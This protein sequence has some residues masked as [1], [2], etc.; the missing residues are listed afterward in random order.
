RFSNRAADGSRARVRRRASGD[1][2]VI[3][4]MEQTHAAAGL[5]P[6]HSGR[7]L[8]VDDEERI[9]HLL[10]RF[11]SVAGYQVDAVH[12]GASALQAIRQHPPDVV[13]LDVVMPVMDGFE[14]CRRL[15]NDQA[16]RLLPVVLV[17]ALSEQ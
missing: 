16:T 8:I 13:V 11:L 1:R 9:V 15:K 2:T 5:I 6:S 4:A 12:D 17:T 3:D 14:T 7:V 10:T